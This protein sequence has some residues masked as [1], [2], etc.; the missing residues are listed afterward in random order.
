MRQFGDVVHGFCHAIEKKLLRTF[1]VSVPIWSR[2]Q[3]PQPSGLPLS[4]KGSG[5]TERRLRR[6]QT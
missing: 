5:Y 3:A 1:F 2:Y 6:N 4:Q